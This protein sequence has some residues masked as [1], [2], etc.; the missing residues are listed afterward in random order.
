MPNVLITGANK[1]IGF[2]TA[3]QLLLKGF[4]VIISGRSKEKLSKALAILKSESDSVE[5]IHMDVAF[6]ASIKGAAIILSERN[7]QI[8]VLINNAAI[9]SKDDQSLI[10]QDFNSFLAILNTN[11]FGPMKVIQA[12]LPLMKSGGRIINISSG[13]GSMSDPVGG[14]SPAYCVSKSMLNALTRNLAFELEAKGISVNSVCPGWVRTELG[15]KAA[16][17]SIQQGAETP[18]WLASEAPHQ[19]TGKFFRDKSVIKW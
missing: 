14:W 6:E 3:R 16:P 17:R 13:G 5:M 15:G 9:M 11:S 18:V 8:D 19:L 4:H 10:K 1:G 7:I 12:I 2:E